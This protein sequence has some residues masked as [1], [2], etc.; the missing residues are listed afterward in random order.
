MYNRTI[1]SLDYESITLERSTLEDNTQKTI[2]IVN[3]SF[4]QTTSTIEEM[5]QVLE[6]LRFRIIA[7]HND[8]TAQTF[9]YLSQ[10]FNEYLTHESQNMWFTNRIPETEFVKNTKRDLEGEDIKIL[11]DSITPGPISPFASGNSTVTNLFRNRIVYTGPPIGSIYYDAPILSIMPTDSEENII[12]RSV[13]DVAPRSPAPPRDHF[14]RPIINIDDPIEADPVTLERVF[15]EPA[16]FDLSHVTQTSLDQLTFYMFVYD[17][18]MTLDDGD[19]DLDFPRISLVTGMT[20]VNIATVIGSRTTW[21]PMP[22]TGIR[23]PIGT[24]DANGEFHNTSITEA[25]QAEMFQQITTSPG[26]NI[27]N[28]VNSIFDRVYG[29][30]SRTILDEKPEIKKIIKDDNLFSEFWQTKDGDEN[31]RFAFA[32]DLESCLIKNSYF[33]FLYRSKGISEQLINSTGIMIRS[34][35]SRALSMEMS[36]KR[37][38]LDAVMP[39]ND[40]STGGRST[41]L[42]PHGTFP[43]EPVGEANKIPKVYTSRESTTTTANKI[44]FYEGKVNFTSRANDK[45]QKSSRIQDN[46]NFAYSANYTVYDAAPIYMR[47]L[48]GFFNDAKY[49]VSEIMSTI[50]NSVPTAIGYR[51]GE[52]TDGRDLYNPRTQKLNVPLN[53][54]QIEIMGHTTSADIFLK[55]IISSYQQLL[56]DLVPFKEGTNLSQHF[57]TEFSRN[58][59]LI[60]PLALDD[61]EKLIDVGTQ[62]VYRKLTEIF[63]NDPMGRGLAIDQTSNLQRRGFCQRKV[64]LIRGAHTFSP[65]FIK[66]EDF[67]F[68]MDYIFERDQHNYSDTGLKRISTGEYDLRI[69]KEFEKYF[70]GQGRQALMPTSTYINPAYSYMSP[71]IIRTPD[72][73]QINQSSFGGQH[74]PQVKYDLDTYG[75]LFAD[76]INLRASIKDRQIDPAVTDTN[77]NTSRNEV[78]YH[79]VLQALEQQH[80]TEIVAESKTEFTAPKKMTGDVELTIIKDGAFGRMDLVRNGPLAIPSLIGGEN[81]TDPNTLTYLASAADAL[82]PSPANGPKSEKDKNNPQSTILQ[83]PIKLPFAILGEL[84]VDA[85]LNINIGYE[86]IAFNSL[87]AL[88]ARLN[89]TQNNVKDIIEGPTAQNLPNQVKSAIILATTNQAGDFGDPDNPFDACRPVLEDQDIGTP[90]RLIS[91]SDDVSNEPPFPVTNDPMKIY[92]KFLTFWMNY[93]NIAKVEYL[94]SFRDV[95]EIRDTQ[96]DI[97]FSPRSRLDLSDIQLMP[98]P[99]LDLSNIRLI[100][101]NIQPVSITDNAVKSKTRLPRW[102]L[103]TRSVLAA[104]SAAGEKVMCR[105]RITDPLEYSKMIE[106]L[107]SGESN[108]VESLFER[109]SL[110]ELPIYNQFFLMEPV[111]FKT[112]PPHRETNTR[113]TPVSTALYTV[114]G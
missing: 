95:S 61:L 69:N 80:G 64:P 46:G 86:D 93:K 92:A 81:N 63:P 32:F 44:T 104:A 33:P 71:I 89:V 87:K 19:L 94:H 110:L 106:D 31:Q 59:G 75:Q 109:K 60:D 66:G 55:S 107:K 13:T 100:N 48:I 82:K 101:N 30:L 62:M 70:Q 85:D 35:P 113:T 105:V 43:E 114:A 74:G 29:T 7:V 96:L 16:I 39:G 8:K 88:V 97:Q 6:N 47:R 51:G 67:G 10:K 68:G 34:Q 73:D 53:L 37:I 20:G 54:I 26:S 111:G 28:R 24:R 2:A 91:F 23:I 90:E 25:P 9:D 76:I 56:D 40:L 41:R 78:L 108:T 58:N 72:R 36:R 12:R 15:I 50:V 77:R 14:G 4:T 98:R 3:T 5:D 42:L 57:E 11:R 103:L 84:S 49:V 27:D 83:F 52:V 21:R 79:S 99:G 1:K 65:T 18:S 22:P 17:T 38:S 102:E 112:P 45:S